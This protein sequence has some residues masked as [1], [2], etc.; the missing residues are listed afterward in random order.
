MRRDGWPTIEYT[1]ERLA[2]GL[3]LVL[4]EDHLAP[5]VAVNI[6]YDVGSRHE[7]PGKTGLAHLFEHMMFEGSPNVPKAEHFRLINSAGGNCNATTWVDRTNYFETLPS[8]HLELALWLES[9]RMGGLLEALGQET[10][11]N[12]REVV[13]NERRQ[14]YDNQPYGTWVERLQAAVFPPGHPYHHST[15]GSMEDLE[16][17]SLEDVRSFFRTYYA[18]NNAVLTIAGDFDPARAREWVERYFGAIHSN[19]AIPRPPEAEVPPLIGGEVRET[20]PDRVPLSRIYV[21]YRVPRFG[22]REF[23]AL[24]MACAVLA[25]G[26]SS[27]LYSRLVRERRIAQDVVFGPFEWVAGATMTI[28]WVT[29]VPGVAVSELEA[30]FHGLVDG[31]A[32]GELHDGELERARAAIE[33]DELRRF[34]RTGERADRL[35]MYATLLDDPGIINRRLPDLLS[36]TADEIRAAARTLFLPDNRAVIT[37]VPGEPADAA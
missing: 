4:A 22:T 6:W 11:D 5:V 34:V 27:R 14:R 21:G 30:E 25:E 16:A 1:D 37:F 24:L 20:V 23:D 31:L 26:R 28:G 7:A 15:I 13:K 36:V 33:R 18:P 3:R 29:A 8:H 2:N 17:A 12:Q 19:P 9:D 35:S 10:L 32:V